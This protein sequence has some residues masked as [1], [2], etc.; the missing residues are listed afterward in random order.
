MSQRQR[1]DEAVDS[2][3]ELGLKEYQARCFVAL[4]RLDAGTAKEISEI[5][6]VP[7]T[8]VYDA[9]ENLE[10]AGLVFTQHGSPKRF[11]AV[12][13]GEAAE[14]LRR[15]KDDRIDTL[16]THLNSLEPPDD[17][18]EDVPKQEV[19]S[20]NGSAP[21]QART[22]DAIEEADVEIILLVVDEA[23]LTDGV[24]ERLQAADERGLNV[25]VGG[26]T[27]VITD[28]VRNAVPGVTVFESELDWLLGP[29]TSEEVAISRLLLTDRERLLVGSFYPDDGRTH[30]E[31]AV[32]ATGLENGVVVVLRRLLQSGL[33]PDR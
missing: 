2:L 14:T 28:T 16:E 27:E 29:K 9:I 23:L 7:R 22:E 20:L 19:W 15:Q 5:S 4:T 11:R 31:Q 26:A 30:E 3:Q 18:S 10:E 8:R 32:F 1:R 6:A 21:I 13:I 25:T 33:L 17:G 12:D 24:V